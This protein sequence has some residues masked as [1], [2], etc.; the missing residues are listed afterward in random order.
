MEL[1]H[2]PP[3]GFL[4]TEIRC[5]YEIPSDMKKVWAVELDL[6]QEFDAVV[7][8]YHLRY[9]A[10]SGTLLG[11]VRHQGFIPW[12]DDMDVSMPREDYETL[13]SV[14]EKEFTHPYFFQTHRTEDGFMRGHAQLRNSETTAILE[15][16]RDKVGLN[17]G[18]FFDIFPMD[19]IPENMEQDDPFFAE[20]RLVRA[21]ALDKAN[22]VVWNHAKVKSDSLFYLR[23]PLVLYRN[24]QVPYDVE[25]ERFEKLCQKYNE[26][27]SHPWGLLMFHGLETRDR[28]PR[29]WFEHTEYMPFE[30]VKV[31]VPG[32]YDAILTKQYGDY[33]EFVKGETYHGGTFFDTENS[34]L[35]YV[36]D[37]REKRKTKHHG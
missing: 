35:K 27:T 12:D 34:Y 15:C 26:D 21:K 23:H 25:Y 9:W 14:A 24:H 2:Q 30:Y 3:E 32:E 4:E 5:G 8:K 19:S 17:Q 7:R 33:M 20:L 28:W 29:A 18:I 10:N 37:T 36:T 13:C 6:F 31:P 1:K 22:H 11:A 16:E